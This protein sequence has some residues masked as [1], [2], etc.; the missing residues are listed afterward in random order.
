[1]KPA[2]FPM[3]SLISANQ[4]SPEGSHS[5]GAPD[6]VGLAVDTSNVTG[7]RIGVPGNVRNASSDM[8]SG[9]GRRRNASPALVSW[10]AETRH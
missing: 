4:S 2:G 5:A 7:S 6:H 10:E 9:I 8:A 3:L 1:M